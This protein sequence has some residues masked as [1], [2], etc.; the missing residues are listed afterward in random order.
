[1]QIIIDIPKEMYINALNG[2]LCG[3]KTIVNAIEN[4]TPLPKGKWKMHTVDNGYNID[5]KCSNCGFT[6]HTDFFD[7]RYC[8]NCGVE[9]EDKE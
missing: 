3:S 2:Y 4:G 7:Y 5:W 9:M 6:M 1:M 8:P